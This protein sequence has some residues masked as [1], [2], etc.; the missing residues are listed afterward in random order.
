MVD[1]SLSRFTFFPII[2]GLFRTVF[3]VSCKSSDY[4]FALLD[5][6]RARNTAGARAYAFSHAIDGAVYHCSF[7][8]KQRK[9]SMHQPT[10]II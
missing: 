2:F 4:M 6:K 9:L 5:D 10:V 8:P 7:Y 1:V 3:S